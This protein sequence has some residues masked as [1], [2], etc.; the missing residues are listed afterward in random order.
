MGLQLMD[1]NDVVATGLALV[2]LIAGVQLAVPALKARLGNRRSVIVPQAMDVSAPVLSAQRMTSSSHLGARA[3]FAALTSVVTMRV[4]STDGVIRAQATAREKLDATELSLRRLVA[5]M[6][7]VMPPVVM[8]SLEP[9]AA[10]D[11]SASNASA[12]AA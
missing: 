1:L 11:R 9:S 2:V 6:G 10:K 3:Q 7:D 4:L 5:D 12:M 8:T